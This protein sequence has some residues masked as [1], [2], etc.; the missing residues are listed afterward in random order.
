MNL[1]NEYNAISNEIGYGAASDTNGHGTKVA[2]IIAGCK[3]GVFGEGVASGVNIMPIKVCYDNG[4]CSWTAIFYGILYAAD[5]GADVINMSSS[6]SSD[7]KGES[8]F[9]SVQTLESIG[10]NLLVIRHYDSGAPYFVSRNI[11]I[12]VINAGDGSHAHP[13]QNLID[14]YTVYK[15]LGSI[16]GI[17]LT[18]LGDNVHSRVA[19]STILGFSILGANIT[20]CA[21]T[22]MNAQFLSDNS[23]KKSEIFWPEVNYSDDLEASLKSA[24][25]VMALRTQF[26]RKSEFVIPNINEYT[27]LFKLSEDS[28]RNVSKDIKIL[29]PGPMNLGIEIDGYVSN[30]DKSL[31]NEQVQNSVSMRMA[32]LLLLIGDYSLDSI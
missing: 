5:N 30:S 32:V 28:F 1:V 6:G 23:S 12:P 10:A 25:L 21:P 3:G 13:T 7:E 19:R 8:L 9:N 14:L 17:N 24:D 26:E 27:R 2:L 15:N 29:H 20:I 16:E 31:I 22:T 11:D 4:L 18:I